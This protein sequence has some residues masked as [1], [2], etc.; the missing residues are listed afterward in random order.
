MKLQ[1][2]MLLNTNPKNIPNINTLFNYIL[3]PFQVESIK[4][5]NNQQNVLVTAHTSA[6]KS[7]IAEYAIAKAAAENVRVF[8]TSPIKTLSNQ[9]LHDLKKKSKRLGLTENDIGIMTGDN[10]VNPDAQCVVMT[11]EILRNMLYKSNS[12]IGDLKY[13]IFDEV[14]YFNDKERGH[15]WEECMILLPKDVILIMLSATLSGAKEFA[16]WIESI[17]GIKTN[18]VS[19]PFRPTPLT[20]NVLLPKSEKLVEIYNSNQKVFNNKNYDEIHKQFKKMKNNKQHYNYK[21][22]FTPLVQFLKK[23]RGLPMIMFS[24]SRKNCERYAQLINISLVDHEEISEIDK[25]FNNLIRTLLGANTNLEQIFLLKKLL[26]KGIGIHHSGL[27]HTLKEIVEN[28]FER[29]LIKVLFATETFAVGVNMPA[30]TVVFTHLEKYDNSGLRTLT[31][32]EY[33]QMSGR[34]GRRGIDH[35]GTVINMPLFDMLPRHE[36][37]GLISG[38]SQKLV[39]Q[40][41]LEPQFIL[42]TICSENQSCL[43]VLEKSLVNKENHDIIAQNNLQTEKLTRIKD[44]LIQLKAR[45]IDQSILDE[46]KTY[47]VSED[48]LNKPMVSHKKKKKIRKDIIKIKKKYCVKDWDKYYNLLKEICKT[49]DEIIKVTQHNMNL[50][51]NFSTKISVIVKY[52]TQKKYLKLNEGD[53]EQSLQPSNL[54]KKG[55]IAA[56]INEVNELLLTEIIDSKILEKHSQIEILTILGI[57]TEGKQN[58]DITINYLDIPNNI[59]ETIFEI[60]E[61]YNQLDTE[62]YQHNIM[63]KQNIN[64]RFAELT[65]KWISGDQHVDILLQPYEIYIGNFIKNMQKIQNICKEIIEICEIIEM[66]IL[67]NKLSNVSPLIVKGPLEFKSFYLS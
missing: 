43:A 59:K 8:Y 11:T 33:L 3:D 57:F 54:T 36:M 38:K 35:F 39:S 28:L 32:A 25:T 62:T 14:H 2:E 55:I 5:I 24:F 45:N 60:Q 17:R 19:T 37:I 53:N 40:F 18:L 22:S 63:F 27:H 6:G 15:V 61:I 50:K 49:E 65:Y 12:N 9:K 44:S 13:V 34:A 23:K 64:L 16:D 26:L 42:K 7:T 48:E 29:G 51:N 30:K 10:K 67:I 58:E 31:T 41:L 21:S 46:V 4:S 20:H 56:E 52:L 47:L 1:K 66:P